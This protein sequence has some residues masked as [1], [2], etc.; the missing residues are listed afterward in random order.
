M[1]DKLKDQFFT[2]NSID[3]L[4]VAIRKHDPVFDTEKFKQLV[5]DTQ[6]NKL[7]LKGRMHHIARCLHQCLP[8]DYVTALVTLVKAAPA[9][10]GFEGMVF[11]DFV[12]QF[13]LDYWEESLNALG[14]FT[15][16]SS[17]EF[18]IRPFIAKNPELV[19]KYMMIWAENEN[20]RVR[21]F[22]SEGCRPRLPWAMILHP[23]IIDP[24]PV[25]NVLEKLKNDPSEFVRKSVANNLND[26]SKDN[27]EIALETA[28]RWYGYSDR[29]NWIVKQGLRTLLKK[30]NTRAL[31]LFGVAESDQFEVQNLA[32]DKDKLKIGESLHFSFTLYN[33]GKATLPAR[34]EYVVVYV[35]SGEKKSEKVFQIATK[36]IEPGA[37]TFKRTLSLADL[38][39]RKHHPGIHKIIIVVNGTRM[40]ECSFILLKK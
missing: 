8:Q 10:K 18:A 27:P 5:F 4:A 15:K 38:T 16:Y 11:P 12:E 14:H 34:L 33:G 24:A 2:N 28:V 3:Q 17:S 20:E 7:E 35:K 29:T 32:V 26:I 31:T 1:A 39:T 13:G 25:L 22:A 21:R 9:V 6:W 36:E 23:F 30:G 37:I 19:M 40:A